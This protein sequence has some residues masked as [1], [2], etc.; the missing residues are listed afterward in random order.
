MFL[1]VCRPTNTQKYINY[2]EKTAANYAKVA[3]LADAPDL[4]SVFLDCKVS[5]GIEI[6][7]I[8]NSLAFSN[9]QQVAPD[10]TK[11]QSKRTPNRTPV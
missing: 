10:S 11:F 8:F 1:P 5:H 7:F 2:H 6:H 3:K 4:G 9:L